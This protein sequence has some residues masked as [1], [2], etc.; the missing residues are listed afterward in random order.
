[1]R[2]CGFGK[3]ERRPDADLELAS[4]DPAKHVSR[5]PHEVVS[6]PDIV[7]EARTREEQR[8]GNDWLEVEL[9]DRPARLPVQH[10]VAP[11]REAV[12]ALVEGIAADRVVDH[13]ETLP[14]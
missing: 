10:H 11:W 14:D 12:E 5:P 6:R 1:M 13:L 7:D 9:R 8:L 4:L 2:L 3:R